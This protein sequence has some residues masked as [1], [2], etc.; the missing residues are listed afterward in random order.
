[1]KTLENRTLIYD[2][3]CPMCNIY[4]KGFTKCGMLN[5]NSREAFSEMSDST[6]KIIDFQRSKNE[7]ALINTE[8]NSVVYGLDS[9]LF[10]IGNSFPLLEKIAKIPPLYWFFKRLYKLVSYNRKQMVPS[11]KDETENACVPDFNVKYRI[12]YIALVLLFSAYILSLYNAKMFPFFS[13]HFELKLF[14]CTMQIIW[15]TVF[16]GWFLKGK[17]WDYL[18]NMMTVSLLGTFLLTPVLLVD[19][20]ENFYFIYFGIVV[21]LMFLEHLRRCRILKIGLFPTLSWMAFR[22]IFGVILFYIISKSFIL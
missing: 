9:L 15:Q 8:N 10:I 13:Q 14:I 7:I 4:S 3:D 1:M 6:R 12:T 17:F 20:S 11:S 18:G 2:S 21:L 22:V 16:L 5:K 19:F